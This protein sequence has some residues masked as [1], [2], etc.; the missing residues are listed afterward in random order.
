MLVNNIGVIVNAKPPKLTEA[1][2]F[3]VVRSAL[4]AG[5]Y[6]I[7]PHARQRCL[8]REISVPDIE[9]VLLQGRR[10]KNRDRFDFSWQ[11]WS[12]GF[13]G[14]TVDGDHLRVIVVLLERQGIV[15]IVRLGGDDEED[16]SSI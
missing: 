2:L 13:E 12:Y 15:T 7:L 6:V 10:V 4:E 9:F 14:K 11:R 3:S 8:E 5:D 16:F 1:A